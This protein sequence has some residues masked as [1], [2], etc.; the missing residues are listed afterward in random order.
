MNIKTTNL[1]RGTLQ[2][3]WVCWQTYE[4]NLNSCHI[5]LHLQHPPFTLFLHVA[6]WRI[7]SWSPW[8]VEYLLH[9]FF[10]L[11]TSTWYGPTSVHPSVHICSKHSIASESSAYNPCSSL[12]F[13]EFSLL[14]NTII[15]IFLISFK[16]ESKRQ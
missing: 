5:R 9:G 12:C 15:I 14:Y 11:L 2:E 3:S 8:Q 10:S 6:K 1:Q 4:C 7:R 16:N 13:L